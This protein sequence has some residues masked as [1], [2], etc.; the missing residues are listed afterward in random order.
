MKLIFSDEAGIMDPD[1]YYLR[2]AVIIPEENYFTIQ[3]KFFELKNKYGIPLEEELKASDI[4]FLKR[5]QTKGINLPKKDRDRLQKYIN[6]DYTYYLE[7]IEESLKLLPDDAV[8]IVVWTYFFDKVFKD[9]SEIE[10]DFLQ[11]IMPRIE[12]ELKEQ[13]ERGIIFYD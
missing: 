12:Y 1:E 9:Q 5:Y 11:T 3:Q 4:W 2:C 13:K 7:F 10:K 6:K 8:I